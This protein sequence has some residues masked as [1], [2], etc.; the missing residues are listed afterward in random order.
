MTSAPV[1]SRTGVSARALVSQYLDSPKLPHSQITRTYW[2]TARK[3]LHH[4]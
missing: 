2:E 4:P 1:A 3:S